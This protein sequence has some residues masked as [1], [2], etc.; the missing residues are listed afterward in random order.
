MLA[1]L[2]EEREVMESRVRERKVNQLAL[3]PFAEVEHAE[4]DRPPLLVSR[5]A[6]STPSGGD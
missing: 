1:R 5:D 2:E 6:V 3:C 4:S